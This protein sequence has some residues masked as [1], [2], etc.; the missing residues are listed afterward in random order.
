MEHV[1]VFFGGHRLQLP[2]PPLRIYTYIYLD[3]HLYTYIYMY[4]LYICIHKYLVL[5]CIHT[6]H[7]YLDIY[8]YTLFFLS[9]RACWQLHRG[10]AK[11]VCH[12]ATIAVRCKVAS[13]P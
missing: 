12:A 2:C 5:N 11:S 4:I 9:Q 8:T 10:E 1:R 6:T 3:L 7:T 13:M